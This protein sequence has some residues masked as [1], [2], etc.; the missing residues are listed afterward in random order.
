M[1]MHVHVPTTASYCVYK[2]V[3]FLCFHF[4]LRGSGRRPAQAR[5]FGPQTFLLSMVR[6]PAWCASDN[7][8]L[9]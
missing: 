9:G 6:P 7:E 5:N 4:Q 8:I 1:S 2:R 3:R